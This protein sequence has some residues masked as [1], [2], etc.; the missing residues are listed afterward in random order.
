MVI[1]IIMIKGYVDV[2]VD[3]DYND[4]IVVVGDDA[5]VDNGE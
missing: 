4:S 3:D 1:M 2:D 5:A